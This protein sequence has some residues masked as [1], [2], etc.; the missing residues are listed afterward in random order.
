MPANADWYADPSGRHQVRY[1]DGSAWTDHVANSGV[2]GSDVLGI[3]APA[4]IPTP[5][6]AASTGGGWMDKVKAVA[7]DVADQG[8]AAID[9]I[10]STKPANQSAPG[11]PTSAN[12]VGTSASNSPPPMGSP[13][14]TSQSASPPSA[15]PPPTSSPA[16]SSSQ[17][18]ASAPG[19]HV[20]VA[21]Q[22]RKLADLRDEGVLTEDEFA[23]QKAKILGS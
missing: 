2:A 5:P 9:E 3:D 20:D 22:L 13:P 11:G 18:P 15:S 14:P 7:Q 21:T 4:P 8:K 1:W 19:A 16:T 6:P 17:P 12:G 23:A 10:S